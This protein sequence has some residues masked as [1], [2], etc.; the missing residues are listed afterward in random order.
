MSPAQRASAISRRKEIWE[1][2]HPEKAVSVFNKNSSGTSCPTGNI[3][4]KNPPLRPEQF[5][6]DTA[7]VSGQSK[8]DI[9]RHV[10][11]AE[12]L[13]S[14]QMSEV[15]S[16]VRSS[17]EPSDISDTFAPSDFV[18]FG[19]FRTFRTMGYC[20]FLVLLTANEPATSLTP[21]YGLVQ[22]LPACV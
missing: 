20:R 1:A 2:L 21:R 18:R 15:P 7:K 17:I 12:S 14:E 4:Y 6:A 22:T 9:N 11:R 16:E 3:G 10:A 19:H 13:E 5:A 8:Q